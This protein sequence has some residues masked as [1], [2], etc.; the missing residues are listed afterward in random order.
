VTKLTHL[1]VGQL[2]FVASGVGNDFNSAEA[3]DVPVPDPW[4][5]MRKRVPDYCYLD[6]PPEPPG[7]VGPRL[8]GGAK[9]LCPPVLDA[10]MLVWLETKTRERGRLEQRVAVDEDG[11][12][13]H[14]FV[15]NRC[16]VRVEPDAVLALTDRGRQ[17]DL[18]AF[19]NLKRFPESALARKGEACAFEEAG[20]SSPLLILRGRLRHR[21]AAVGSACRRRYLL[22]GS[23]PGSRG[24]TTVERDDRCCVSRPSNRTI[25]LATNARSYF[26]T[27]S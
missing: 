10:A 26:Y 24:T 11:L 1:L 13:Q 6:G 3:I 21:H 23:A 22:H 25:A 7:D 15:I 27:R 5:A 20:Y 9:E 4:I 12:E 16:H 17:F 8:T 2:D 14:S 19:R 18:L